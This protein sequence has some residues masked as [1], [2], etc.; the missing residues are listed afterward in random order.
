MTLGAGFLGLGAYLDEANVGGLLAEAL[1]ADVEAVLADQTSG[2]GADAAVRFRKRP[3]SAFPSSCSSSSLSPFDLFL[4]PRRSTQFIQP[5]GGGGGWSIPRAGALAVG[6]R[7]RVPDGFVSHFDG[8]RFFCG[9]AREIRWVGLGWAGFVVVRCRDG[10]P[11]FQR[12]RELVDFGGDFFVREGLWVGGW[13]VWRVAWL[14][15]DVLESLESLDCRV[16]CDSVC[17]CLAGTVTRRPGSACGLQGQHR[18][19]QG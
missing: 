1:T 3:Q 2:V 18:M 5:G 9:E 8:W 16:G 17:R 11:K 13:W 12:A 6:A 10:R 4:R 7:A 15:L 19:R 14:G